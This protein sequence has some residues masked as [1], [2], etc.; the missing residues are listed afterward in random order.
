[1]LRDLRALFGI[2]NLIIVE[3][4]ERASSRFNPNLPAGAPPPRR[5]HVLFWW[6][7]AGRRHQE[8]L[9]AGVGAAI[10]GYLEAAEWMHNNTLNFP[11][12]LPPFQPLPPPPLQPL[13]S[14]LLF[15]F[16]PLPPPLQLNPLPDHPLQLKHLQLPPLAPPLHFSPS[17][18][19]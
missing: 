17:L 10:D 6:M 18:Q 5:G 7:L 8:L 11:H 12:P 16:P 1:M 3:R 9:D 19:A 14:P 4:L 15:P 2:R 13:L